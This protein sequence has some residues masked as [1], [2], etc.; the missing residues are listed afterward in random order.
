MSPSLSFRVC[1]SITP[2]T[3]QTEG[4]MDTVG[5][6]SVHVRLILTPWG[7][8][9]GQGVNASPGDS[10]MYLAGIYHDETYLSVKQSFLDLCNYS[11]DLC[12]S[13]SQSCGYIIS[14]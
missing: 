4:P 14:L 9:G 8:G 10:Y 6:S 13:E 11:F 12:L 7:R 1:P 3:E 2:V 5:S